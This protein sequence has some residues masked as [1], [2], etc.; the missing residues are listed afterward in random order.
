M[1]HIA[2]GRER[3]AEDIVEAER[4]ELPIDFTV[5][6]ADVV[7][8]EGPGGSEMRAE[9]QPQLPLKLAAITVVEL[10]PAKLGIEAPAPRPVA[11]SV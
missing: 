9:H 3:R 5:H 6:A 11:I 1:L 2:L 4:P 7:D 8:R 10:T